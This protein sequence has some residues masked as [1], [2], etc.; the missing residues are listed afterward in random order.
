MKKLL[1]MLLFATFMTPVMAQNVTPEVT[2]VIAASSHGFQH[3]GIPVKDMEKTIKFYEG[4]GFKVAHKTKP[5][6]GREFVF[7]N[8]G[9]MMLEF[10]PSQTT[11][12]KPGAV[13]HICLD[14]TNIEVLY[15]TV[16]KA[17]YTIV[18]ELVTIPF[19]EK[20]CK[21][22]KIEGPDKEIIEWCE[23]IK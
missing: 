19:W 10:I 20:G 4:I 21:C 14:A 15:E 23:I 9:S 12:E 6:N 3:I 5:L 11:P 22:F 7:M 1:L 16:K 2:A 17:G 13:D 8:S 18:N